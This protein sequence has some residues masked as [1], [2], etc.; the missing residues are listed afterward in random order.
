MEQVC[1]ILWK[2]KPCKEKRCLQDTM[3]IPSAEACEAPRRLNL[4]VVQFEWQIMGFEIQEVIRLFLHVLFIFLALLCSSPA[5][6][7]ILSFSKCDC[8]CFFT[9]CSSLHWSQWRDKYRNQ[10]LLLSVENHSSNWPLHTFPLYLNNINFCLWQKVMFGTAVVP[11]ILTAWPGKI[12][13]ELFDARRSTGWRSLELC[14]CFS[15]WCNREERN[16]HKQRENE[17]ER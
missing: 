4:T 14:C 8:T 16:R 17:V 11:Q 12:V 7:S 9:P 2:G 13:G 15:C 6:F 3:N 10:S 5:S 1:G